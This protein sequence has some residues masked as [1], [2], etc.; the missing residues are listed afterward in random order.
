M[1]EPLGPS[2]AVMLPA[3]ASNVTPFD[4]DEVAEPFR[5]VLDLDRRA[6]ASSSSP[7]LP[8]LE[9]LDR[10]EQDAPRPARAPAQRCTPM[11]SDDPRSLGRCRAWPSRCDPGSARSRSSTAPISPIARAVDERDPV[12][13]P[14]ADVRE[15][16]RGGS[17]AP[18][19]HRAFALRPPPPYRP[20][21]GRERPLGS[22][23]G[24]AMK[25]VTSTS[26]GNAKM[27][28]IPRASK[29]G[30]NHPPRPNSNTHAM[31]TVTGDSAKGRSTSAFN[32]ASAGEALPNEYPGDDHAEDPGDHHGDDRDDRRE[33]RRVAHVHLREGIGHDVPPRLEGR[34]HDARQRGDQQHQEVEEAERHE[35][36]PQE[37]APAPALA[38]S[39][40][41]HDRLLED[42]RA[43]EGPS[44]RVRT[45]R[46]VTSTS[47][48]AIANSTV[49]TAAA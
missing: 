9:Q 4:G 17:S 18:S 8:A 31:P 6:H 32:Q 34:P 3:S 42:R 33:Q 19:R 10:D 46:V 21:R 12:Q 2:K 38:D 7:L 29:N 43:H 16:S 48:N 30:S 40:I 37:R 20:L 13:Q 28:W 49:A 47:T 11:G 44:F 1:P 27:M 15:A 5:Q 35:S 36:A 24:I 39:R 22:T 26:D 14:P 23:N 25:M 41:L 45:R